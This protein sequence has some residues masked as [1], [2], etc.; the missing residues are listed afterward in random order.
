MNNREEQ[1]LGLSP[2]RQ[3]QPRMNFGIGVWNT[4]HNK[5]EVPPPS[6]SSPFLVCFGLEK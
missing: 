1:G 3:L 5:L 4:Y 2:W 6:P